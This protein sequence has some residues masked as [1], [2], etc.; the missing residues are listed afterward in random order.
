MES[1]EIS[2]RLPDVNVWLSLCYD[3]HGHHQA[4]VDWREAV[5]I[6]VYFCH[7]TQMSLLRL[8]TNPR[9]MRSDMRTPQDAIGV[10][11]ELRSDERVRYA[12]ETPDMESLW[13]SLMAA[14]SANGGVWTDAWLAAFA[15]AHGSKLVSFDAGMRR[16]AAL[17]PEV[18][19]R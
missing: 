13:F 4:A 14:P 6:P 11:R 18:L 9:V 1:S 10:Y 17:R 16:W 8:L 3:R 15:L 2:G 12:H 5:R 7:V 19:G